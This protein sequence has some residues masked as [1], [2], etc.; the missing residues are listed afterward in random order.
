MN[1][2]CG[3]IGFTAGLGSA[4]NITDAAGTWSGFGDTDA[5]RDG[6]VVVKNTSSNLAALSKII[7][8]NFIF[9]V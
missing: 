6:I 9:A 2:S 5:L 4:Q 7:A 8:S 3:I 1:V